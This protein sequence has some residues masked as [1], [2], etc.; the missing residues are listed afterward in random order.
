VSIQLIPHPEGLGPPLGRYSH[1]AVGSGE[2]VAVAGQVGKTEHGELA[3]PDLSS[4]A[5]Q[6]YAN[7]GTALGAAGCRFEDVLKM[8]TFLVAA[9]L[10]PEFMEVRGS[11]FAEIYPG[12]LYPPNTLC[13]LSGLVEPA[14]LFEVEA[15]ALRPRG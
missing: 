5:R 3:G 1:V 15:L 11:I 9:D 6:A 12:G 10:I 13:I 8:T 4:Q 7:L 14:L 2:L